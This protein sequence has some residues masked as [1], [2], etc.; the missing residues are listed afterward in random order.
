MKIKEN[1]SLAIENK[2][3]ANL[4]LN[5]YNYDIE[6]LHPCQFLMSEHNEIELLNLIRCKLLDLKHGKGGLIEFVNIDTDID[7]LL[8]KLFCEYSLY[9]TE[10]INEQALTHDAIKTYSRKNYVRIIKT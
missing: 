5:L 8:N 1:L 10:I 4:L 2:E 9:L 3:K 7:E 6:M